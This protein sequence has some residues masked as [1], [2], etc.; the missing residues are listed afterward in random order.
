MR[1]SFLG[2]ANTTEILSSV[3]PELASNI[4]FLVNIFR[5]L[6]GSNRNLHNLQYYKYFYLQKKGKGN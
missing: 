4:S 5:A 1:G 6:G 3:S 2:M